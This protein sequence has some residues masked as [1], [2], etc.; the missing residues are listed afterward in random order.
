MYRKHVWIC[1]KIIAWSRNWR[2]LRIKTIKI[3]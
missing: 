1:E 2:R 3:I